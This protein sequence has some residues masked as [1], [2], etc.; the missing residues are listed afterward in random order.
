[1]RGGVEIGNMMNMMQSQC[2]F[3]SLEKSQYDNL[4]EAKVFEIA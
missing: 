1:M 2:V 3:T 4:R